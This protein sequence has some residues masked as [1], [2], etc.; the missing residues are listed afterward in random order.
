MPFST[1][2]HVHLYIILN[3]RKELMRWFESMHPA[4]GRAFFPYLPGAF[5]NSIEGKS[6]ALLYIHYVI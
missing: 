5:S 3:L 4:L 6:F 2:C 1:V